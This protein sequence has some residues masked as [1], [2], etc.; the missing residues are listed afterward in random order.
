MWGS[1]ISPKSLAQLTWRRTGIAELKE[2][3]EKRIK[4]V[5][6]GIGG[7]YKGGEVFHACK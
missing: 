4:N 1:K 2:L 6:G 7:N 3:G 5:T